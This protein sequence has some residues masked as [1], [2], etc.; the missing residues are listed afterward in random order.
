MATLM[1]RPH[2]ML[3][4]VNAAVTTGHYD[5]KRPCHAHQCGAAT[6]TFNQRSRD[7]GHF[8]VQP[9]WQRYRALDDVH[10]DLHHRGFD[11]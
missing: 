8:P 4:T 5:R 1:A 10:G 9:G 7:W 11:Q 3:W 6:F 2:T